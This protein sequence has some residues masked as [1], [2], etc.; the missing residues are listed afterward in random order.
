MTWPAMLAALSVVAAGC[1][2]SRSKEP[3]ARSADSSS[4]GGVVAATSNATEDGGP[5]DAGPEVLDATT[6]DSFYSE[7]SAEL[8]LMMLGGDEPVALVARDGDILAVTP[9]GRV[10]ETLATH[11]TSEVTLVSDD[12]ISYRRGPELHL[13][14]LLEPTLVDVAVATG[15]PPATPWGFS[16]AV[17]TDD[18]NAFGVVFV[19]GPDPSLVVKTDENLLEEK[20][21]PKA[22]A[23]LRKARP[24]LTPEG[25]DFLRRYRTLHGAPLPRRLLAAQTA[26]LSQDAHALPLPRAAR[27]LDCRGAC[28][29]SYALPSTWPLQLVVVGTD[30][31]CALL[32]VYAA[33]VWREAETGRFAS[34]DKPATL[35]RNARP[36]PCQVIF[37]SSFTAYAFGSLPSSQTG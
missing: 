7:T 11:P 35:G 4:I 25:A 12:M 14:Y 5:P 6:P 15:L 27:R 3:P 20:A 19:Y 37:N 34:L 26:Q 36:L 32:G 8:T 9:T 33:C 28:G 29:R 21:S 24:T 18:L 1:G 22:I 2:P 17:P 10:V 13:I 30:Y 31:D 23:A 16:S